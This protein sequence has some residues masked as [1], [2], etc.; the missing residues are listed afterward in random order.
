MHVFPFLRAKQTRIRSATK[1]LEIS[2]ITT[3]LIHST[4]SVNYISIS[5]KKNVQGLFLTVA[6][7]KLGIIYNVSVNSKCYHPP[8]DPGAFDQNFCL[9]Q[10]AG[11]LTK[12]WHLT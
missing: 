1:I 6:K 5:Y 10:G 11:I 12:V 9:G 3:V 2:R 8:D 4:V 7:K